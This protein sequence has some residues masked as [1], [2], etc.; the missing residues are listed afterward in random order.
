MEAKDVLV[1]SLMEVGGGS[2]AGRVSV[3]ELSSVTM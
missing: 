2:S 3:A 1:R